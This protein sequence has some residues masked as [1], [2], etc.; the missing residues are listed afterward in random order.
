MADQRRCW[1]CDVRALVKGMQYYPGSTTAAAGQS[2]NLVREPTN[3]VSRY[4]IRVVDPATGRS[5]GHVQADVANV[6]SPLLDRGAIGVIGRLARQRRPTTATAKPFSMPIWLAISARP[7]LAD[8]VRALL[9]R[10][11]LT[12]LSPPIVYTARGPPLTVVLPFSVLRLL[13]DD[14]DDDDDARRAQ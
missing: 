5:M 7:A 3:A 6:L 12:Q 11:G 14:N 8:A 13:E 10:A 9:W 1:L 2:V 4:A